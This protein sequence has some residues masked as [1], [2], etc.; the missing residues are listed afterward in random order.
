MPSDVSVP[1]PSPEQPVAEVIIRPPRLDDAEAMHRLRLMRGSLDYTLALPSERLEGSRRRIESLGPD[2]HSFLAVV[3][4]QVVG[5]AGLHVATGKR[6]HSASLGMSVDD[7][8]QG[9][10]IGRKLLEALLDVAD[11]YLGL[12]RVELEV[13]VDN[14]RAIRLYERLGFEHEGCKRKAVFRSGQYI[15]AL[16]MARLRYSADVVH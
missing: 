10:G 13:L 12:T 2:D 8:F 1:D 9:R 14:P 16:V 11:S 5:M 15:D 4:G 3:D 6:R 7:A